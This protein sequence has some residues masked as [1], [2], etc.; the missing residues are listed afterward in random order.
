[1]KCFLK[2]VALIG[3]ALV[4]FKLAQIAI[5]YLYENYGKRYIQSGDNQ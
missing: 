3:S 5:D 4:L 2:I 1:M